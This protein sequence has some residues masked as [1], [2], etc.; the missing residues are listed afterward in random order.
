MIKNYIKKA[1]DHR[2][3]FVELKSD[4]EVYIG[5]YVILGVFLGW[6]SLLSVM[7]YW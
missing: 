6:S 5:I 4:T 3:Q 2:Y 1:I 7:M